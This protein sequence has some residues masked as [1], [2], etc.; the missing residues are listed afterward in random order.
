MGKT[1]TKSVR[2]R[3]R[4][5]KVTRCERRVLINMEKK[6]VSKAKMMARTRNQRKKIKR[7]AK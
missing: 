6:A 3:K 7:L 1:K 5:K 2:R 4:K